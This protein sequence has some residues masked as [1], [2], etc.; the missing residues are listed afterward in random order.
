MFARVGKSLYLRH[1]VVRRIKNGGNNFEPGK[2]SGRKNG[3]NRKRNN[4]G[5]NNNG[6]NN[7]GRNNNGRNNNGR[8][9][10]GRNNN[11]RN[12]NGRNGN[13]RLGR[14]HNLPLNLIMKSLKC[15]QTLPTNKLIL[16]TVV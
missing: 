8:N 15:R 12:N 10:N 4:N 11:G 2:E 9:N 16:P 1:L 3:R 13:G 5:R 7:N 6:R 14:R